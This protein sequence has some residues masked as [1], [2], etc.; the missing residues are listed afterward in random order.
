MYRENNTLI[1]ALFPFLEEKFLETILGLMVYIFY[2][3]VWSIQT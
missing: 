1:D 2:Y 3:K